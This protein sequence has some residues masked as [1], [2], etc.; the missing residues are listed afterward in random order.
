MPFIHSF[1][2]TRQSQADH[3]K[4]VLHT[5]CVMRFLL[6]IVYSY[7]ISSLFVSYYHEHFVFSNRNKF[8]FRYVKLNK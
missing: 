8:N 4:N 6:I 7:R 3:P 2:L 5:V 1:S